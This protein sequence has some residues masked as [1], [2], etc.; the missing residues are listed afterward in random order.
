MHR[1]PAQCTGLQH[2]LHRGSRS[3]AEEGKDDTIVVH[4]AS[5]GSV[6]LHCHYTLIQQRRKER[7]AIG[8]LCTAMLMEIFAWIVYFNVYTSYTK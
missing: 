7:N 2:W 5:S 3:V 1:D 4:V 6:Y 8:D